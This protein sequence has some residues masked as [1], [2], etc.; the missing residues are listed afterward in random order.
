MKNTGQVEVQGIYPGSSVNKGSWDM[1]GWKSEELE[2]TG[3]INLVNRESLGWGNPGQN[4]S[5][6]HYSRS[7][8]RNETGMFEELKERSVTELGKRG[9]RLRNGWGWRCRQGLTAVGSWITCWQFWHWA[10]E[11]RKTSAGWILYIYMWVLRVVV[12]KW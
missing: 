6:T 12:F 2:V 5:I 9:K 1:D 10:Q 4:Y 11:E 7:Y 3:R 8:S